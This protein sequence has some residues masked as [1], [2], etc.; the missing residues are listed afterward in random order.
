MS[1]QALLQALGMG[2][3]VS[4]GLA[5]TTNWIIKDGFGLLGGL[6]YAGMAKGVLKIV[7]RLIYLPVF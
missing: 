2:A 1:T 5:A 7:V 3:G 6:I 4:I